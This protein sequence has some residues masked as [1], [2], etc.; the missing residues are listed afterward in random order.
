MA[1]HTGEREI[2]FEFVAL[3]NT[4]RVSAICSVTGLEVQVLGPVGAARRDLEQLALR[5]LQRRLVETDAQP[6]PTGGRGGFTV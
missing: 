3:G 5:K 1:G 4:V 6:L 2:Y